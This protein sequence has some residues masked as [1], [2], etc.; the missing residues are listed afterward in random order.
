MRSK[1]LSRQRFAPTEYDRQL[2]ILGYNSHLIGITLPRLPGAANRLV[3]R[4]GGRNVWLGAGRGRRL[5]RGL[6]EALEVDEVEPLVE[7]PADL[8]EAADFGEVEG[9]VQGQAGGLVAG[10]GGDE[11]AGP[12]GG[13]ALQLVLEE[14]AA[15][16]AAVAVGV[17]VNGIFD[18]FGEGLALAEGGEAAPSGDAASLFGDYDGVVGEVA[19][20]EP[21]EAGGFGFGGGLVGGG[22]MEDVVVIN[23][24][25]GGQIL[26]GGEAQDGVG[27]RR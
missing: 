5:R 22:G 3:C 1:S 26:G 9:A 8:E 7:F 24:V 15:E 12:G 19:V 11:G 20:M 23:G 6:E 4:A 25:D 14:E 21:G 10:D 13:G 2:A 18:G 16:S 27:H 17:D